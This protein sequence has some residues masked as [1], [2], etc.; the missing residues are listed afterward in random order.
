MTEENIYKVVVDSLSTHVALLDESGVI[1]ETNRAWQ[2]FGRKNN[3][4][5]P[6]D[7][8]GMNY[9]SICDQLSDNEA[10]E[11]GAI[12]KGIRQVM[13]GQ[14]EEFLTQYPCHSSNVQ[15]WYALRVVR[16]RSKTVNRVIVAHENITPIMKTQQEL[17]IKEQELKDQTEKLAESNVALKVLLGH[18]DEDRNKF[19]ETIID[20]I[21]KLV[22]PYLEKLL[23]GRLTER[24]R[25]LAEIVQDHLKEV[26]SPFLNRLSNVNRFLTPQ[27]ILV[28]AYVR[29]GKTS[30][31]IAEVLEVSVSAVDFHR[32]SIRRK[33][34]LNQTGT[35]L[36]SYLLSLQ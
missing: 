26:I 17:Q 24:D 21:N 23:S 12:G 13:S 28:A 20:N 32:K 25:N 15:R 4:R 34:G 2:D 14:V 1:V 18:R 8:V 22:M 35:N 31:D 19:E 30:K 6:V 36:R 33:L 9:L 11:V 7:C 5:G 27:E 16:Y 10:E 29:E 3:L